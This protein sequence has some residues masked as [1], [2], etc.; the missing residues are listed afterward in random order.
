[1]GSLANINRCAGKTKLENRNWD[2]DDLLQVI[3]MSW[4]ILKGFETSIRKSNEDNGYELI[5]SS[6]PWGCK[7]VPR[8]YWTKENGIKYIRWFVLEENKYTKEEFLRIY[9]WKWVLKTKLY[10]LVDKLWDRDL[11]QMLE[12]SIPEW[13][14]DKVREKRRK[15]NRKQPV[16]FPEGYWTKER[17]FSVL[18]DAVKSEELSRYDIP[19]T[20]D[21]Y[22]LRTKGLHI[23]L[24]KLWDNK[25][26]VLM[27]DWQPGVF[28]SWEFAHAPC[29]FWTKDTAIAAVKWAIEDKCKLQE[30]Q[31]PKIDS[32]WVEDNKLGTP[33][34]KLW[35]KSFHAMINDV[36]PGRFN[37]WDF[38]RVPTGY[39]TKETV[40]KYLRWFVLDKNKYTKE[41]FSSIYSC[42]W[43]QG[44][45]VGRNYE[46]LRAS[47]VDSIIQEVFPEWTGN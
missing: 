47:S 28:K 6:K 5:K 15:R 45:K 24:R 31:I 40:I 32:D 11:L 37:P 46:V 21:W 13:V 22:W 29:G 1:M 19:K 16:R 7:Q 26:M 4:L 35:K 27:E 23:P 36:Y 17:V 18:D 44:T 3:D 41:Q 9:K 42:R 33:F 34:N 20:I 8:G 38:R 43:L 10:Y 39:W 2:K 14:D 12:D 30:S 25:M